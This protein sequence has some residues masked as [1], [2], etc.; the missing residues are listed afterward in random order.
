MQNKSKLTMK[1]LSAHTHTRVPRRTHH[2]SHVQFSSACFWWSCQL[3]PAPKMMF[4]GSFRK[5]L[6]QET[7]YVAR[8]QLFPL[9]FDQNVPLMKYLKQKNTNM[10]ELDTKT[11]NLF[12]TRCLKRCITLSVTAVNKHQCPD[13]HIL[14]SSSF[15]V[16]LP[17]VLIKYW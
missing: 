9:N 14:S 17:A 8:V 13:L 4:E 15:P 7:L 5:K 10:K 12:S 3:T 1:S 16:N 2:Y 11:R 6:L